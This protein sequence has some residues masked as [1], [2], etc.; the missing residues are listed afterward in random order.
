M[1]QQRLPLQLA[2]VVLV[3]SLSA[4]AV[5]GLPVG[6]VRSLTDFSDLPTL[7]DS[8]VYEVT[9]W[10]GA[11][12]G[13]ATQEAPGRYVL[14][15]A[16][17]PGCITRM[18]ICS[19]Q[20]TVTVYFD[21]AAQPQIDVPL[22]SLYQELK[23]WEQGFDAEKLSRF[24][25]VMPLSLRGAAYRND[26]YLPLPFAKSV[27]VVWEGETPQATPPFFTFVVTTPPTGA[28]VQSFTSARLLEETATVYQVAA[29]WRKLS[30]HPWRSDTVLTRYDDATTATGRISLPAGKTAVLFNQAGAG[31]IVSLRLR[32]QPWHKAVDR[33]LVLRAWWDGEDKPSVET[34][35][36]DF[37]A[38]HGGIKQVMLPVGGGEWYHC[39]FPMPFAKG[40]RLTL[41]N[42][43][44]I[45]VPC[46]D[47]EITVRS[48][49]PPATAG[50][51]CARWQRQQLQG[52]AGE[53]VPL[54]LLETTGAGKLVGFNLH[55]ERFKVPITNYRKDDRM[56]LYLDGEAEPRFAGPSLMMYFNNG[57]YTGPCWVSPLSATLEWHYTFGSYSDCHYF[58]NDAPTWRKDARLALEVK[59]DDD[60]AR[61]YTCVV[62]WYRSPEGKDATP[63]FT[64]DDLSLPVRHFPDSLEA[65]DLAPTAK[66][67]SGDLL[68]MDD[69]D[70]RFGAMNGK[71]LSYAPTG[72]GDS[73]TL[74]V[75]GIAQPGRF[76]V[77]ARKLCGPSG[78][79]WKLTVNDKF[80]GN[81]PPTIDFG[82]EEPMITENWPPGW[83]RLGEF[84]F[85]A[86]DNR[87][88]FT[89]LPTP[90]GRPQ[91]GLL[92]GLDALWLEPVKAQ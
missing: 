75:P 73:L 7:S 8:R 76:Y 36:G 25:F 21:G 86:G 32:A 82:A 65:E 41:E 16:Q 40:A 64:R 35:V 33:L 79:L 74:T 83:W 67:S 42:L 19:V 11:K 53:T 47:Y 49:P 1:K 28:P 37:C 45:A 2:A 48:S 92:L 26:C 88:T 46:L 17:G 85:A 43:S 3:F 23:W 70:G 52:N 22:K 58:L 57:F 84:E 60:V 6:D 10:R 29:S 63:G 9:N 24:P 50:R 20:G 87:I 81:E 66:V 27:K 18:T 72:E 30:Q 5:L 89:A 62:Y 78:G 59:V 68:L 4:G 61:D 71:L 90:P 34:P 91:R 51:F 13:T 31:T 69:T 14:L 77:D 12:P 39:Y 54:K 56:A 55:A 38:S 15:D 80:T 44:R